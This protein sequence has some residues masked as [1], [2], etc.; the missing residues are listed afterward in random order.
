[1]VWQNSKINGGNVPVRPGVLG[2]YV[3]ESGIATATDPSFFI[4][5]F[6][7]K[8]RCYENGMEF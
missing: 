5:L 8:T 1:M 4:K 7:L 3:K 2:T 6:K